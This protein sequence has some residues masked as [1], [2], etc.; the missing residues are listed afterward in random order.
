MRR[1]LEPAVGL[2]LRRARGTSSAC[3]RRARRRSSASSRL[4]AWLRASCATARTT[5]PQRAITR[6]FCASLKEVD[7]ATS[8]VASTRDSVTLACWP[9]GPDERLVR[10]TT[11]RRGTATSREIHIGSFTRTTLFDGEPP[12][13]A[14][15][16]DA[17]TNTDG[18]AMGA[19]TGSR[20]YRGCC[21]L[22]A[23]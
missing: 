2:V 8:N 18:P 5:G 9:P 6:A 15:S 13:E 14:D 1:A 11:S 20:T 7:A 23:C 12:L 10:S 21:L 22:L 4:R 16:Q 19:R 17:E 3:V